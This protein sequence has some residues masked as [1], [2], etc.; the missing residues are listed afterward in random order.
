MC[1]TMLVP[2]K[3]GWD[4]LPLPPLLPRGWHCVL[5]LSSEVAVAQKALVSA[6]SPTALASPAAWTAGSSLIQPKG[7]ARTMF[8]SSRRLF[9]WE[10]LV[11]SSGAERGLAQ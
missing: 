2:E 5:L 9:Y 3:G 4:Q 11:P 10:V 8:W 1:G 6:A 7:L